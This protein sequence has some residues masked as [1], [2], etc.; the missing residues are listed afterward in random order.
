MS[1]EQGYA[2]LQTTTE[3]YTKTA[4]FKAS[5][6]H[7]KKKD[8]DNAAERARKKGKRA[9]KINEGEYWVVYTRG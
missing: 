1:W 8:A 3:D 4:R 7:K 6:R 9:R 5:S 2:D